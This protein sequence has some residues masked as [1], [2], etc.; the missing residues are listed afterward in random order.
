MSTNLRKAQKHMQR[1]TE[2]LNQGQLGFGTGPPNT[3]KRLKKI[4]DAGPEKK[5]GM[6]D[7]EKLETL[8]RELKENIVMRE[9]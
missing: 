2:L 8:P 1:A 4:N 5:Q 7:W 3:G 6:F 9:R